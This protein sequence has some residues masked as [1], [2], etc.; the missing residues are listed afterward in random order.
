MREEEEIFS[1]GVVFVFFDLRDPLIVVVFGVDVDEG[2]KVLDSV[3]MMVLL[4]ELAELRVT[5][6][7]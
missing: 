7:L 6:G 1:L 4:L 2:F 5:D 3:V